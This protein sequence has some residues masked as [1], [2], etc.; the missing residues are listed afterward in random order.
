M[1]V[2]VSFSGRN[3]ANQDVANLVEILAERGRSYNF[4]GKIVAVDLRSRTLSLSNHTDDSLRELAFGSLDPASLGL[5]RDGAEITVQAEFDGDRY[6][7]RS[8]AAVPRNP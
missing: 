6:N 1:L 5:L 4:A 7:I 8:V 3:A 2:R